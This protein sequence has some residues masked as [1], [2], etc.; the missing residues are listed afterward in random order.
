MDRLRV[1]SWFT[2]EQQSIILKFYPE[3]AFCT[4]SHVNKEA[5]LEIVPTVLKISIKFVNRISS[6][7]EINVLTNPGKGINGRYG[8]LGAFLGKTDWL[9]RY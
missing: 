7:S 2:C 4:D 9:V 6:V 3:R 1:Q 5:V 8:L